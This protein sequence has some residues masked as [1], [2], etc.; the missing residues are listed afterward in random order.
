MRSPKCRSHL[1]TDR[2]KL[3]SRGAET[4]W[5]RT[6]LLFFSTRSRFC[7]LSAVPHPSVGLVSSY[8]LQMRPLHCLPHRVSRIASRGVAPSGSTITWA[9]LPRSCPPRGHWR[10][11]AFLFPNPFF[12]LTPPLPSPLHPTPP[13]AVASCWNAATDAY[14]C[15][16]GASHWWG[17]GRRRRTGGGGG[18]PRCGYSNRS[19]LGLAPAQDAIRV[20]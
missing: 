13:T 3:A 19:S 1:N 6:I 18:G 16:I 17:S 5:I 9:S 7:S 14:N 8:R 10:H 11:L 20:C 15:I 4:V 12:F 2:Q